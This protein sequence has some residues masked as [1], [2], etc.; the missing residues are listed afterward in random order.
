MRIIGVGT[1][2]AAGVCVG[3]LAIGCTPGAGTG[4][5]SATA[6][7]ATESATAGTGTSV[8]TAAPPTGSAATVTVSDKW[9]GYASADRIGLSFESGTL[10][11]GKFDD[12]GDLV[13]LLRTLG[14]SVLRFGGNTVDTTYTGIEPGPLAGLARLATASGWKVLYSED[15]GN[16]NA[17]QVTSDAQRVSKALGASLLAFACGNEPDLYSGN[18]LRPSSYTESDYL[19]QATACLDAIRAGAP[20]VPLE[21]PDTSDRA[22]LGRYASAEAGKIAWLGQHYY[23]LLC[24]LGGL[25]P[26]VFAT[27]ML[28]PAQA[29]RQATFF[30]G[31][32]AAAK[33]AHAPLLVSETNTA[34]GLGAP[35]VSDAYASALWVI[36]YLL[37]GEEHHV[38]GYYFMGSLSTA[39][40]GYTPLCQTGTNE[41][42]AQPIYYGMLFT[43]LLGTG[44]M[45]Q[46][47]VST[48]KPQD[49]VTA[50][51]LKPTNG[52]SNRLIVEN[53][54]SSAANVTLRP[55]G[56]PGYAAVLHLTGP[57]LLATSGVRIQ[58]E[59]VAGNGTFTPGKA[60]TTACNPGGCPVMLAPYSAVLV[61]FS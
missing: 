45:L 20:K 3:A 12:A 48:A 35:G 61:T 10:N 32:S 54:T 58:G 31:A 36:D 59:S 39:C 57:A 11:S 13:Q 8:A 46:V 40:Q 33:V 5:S 34:C 53:L 14:T 26:A 56:D 27:K 60:S 6:D 1:A 43:H 44:H 28:S 22:W 49:H 41:Y 7:P 19:S 29:A 4:T 16:Y 38:E 9:I 51:A 47:A 25:T 50:F 24:N 52:G 30:I 2:I 18:G 42:A 23:P 55:G 17:A 15:L 37:T 21:G